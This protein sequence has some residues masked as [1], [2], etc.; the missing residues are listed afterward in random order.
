MTCKNPSDLSLEKVVR[1]SLEESTSFF[2][3]ISKKICYNKSSLVIVKLS[4]DK[5]QEIDACI[6]QKNRDDVPS[7]FEVFLRGAT[8]KVIFLKFK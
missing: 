2:R 6:V 4:H 8:F 5:R 3:I 7:Y 1:L